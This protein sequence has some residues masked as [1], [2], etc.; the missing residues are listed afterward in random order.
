MKVYVCRAFIGRPPSKDR[1]FTIK[2]RYSYQNNVGENRV[3]QLVCNA[4]KFEYTVFNIIKIHMCNHNISSRRA[5]DIRPYDTNG[6]TVT[7]RT[8]KNVD[9]YCT[10]VLK[11]K[12]KKCVERKR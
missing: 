4:F 12:M 6:G 7:C 9:I 8:N 11:Y 5:D 3:L 10:F 2:M 1:N